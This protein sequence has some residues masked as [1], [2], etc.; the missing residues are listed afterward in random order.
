MSRRALILGVGGF[1]GSHLAR[2]LLHAGWEVT[3]VVRDPRSPLLEPRLGDIF[4]EV[5]LVAGNA[6]DHGLL[7]KLL[8]GADAVFPFAGLSGATASMERPLVDL[9]ANGR[10]QLVLLE[11]LRTHN[12]DAHVVYPGSRLQYGPC[13]RL[14]VDEDHPQRPVSVYGVH[15]MLAEQYHRLY[16]LAHEIPTTVFRI[17]NPYGPYQYRPDAAFGIVGTFLARAA[18]GEE[19]QVYGGGHQLRDY[20]YIGD[21]VRLCEVA[22]TSPGSAG[23]AYNA[24]GP[25][26]VSLRE[27]AE[28]V[29]ATVGSGR[30]VDAP[31]PAEEGAV[32]TGDYV[33]D[34]ELATRELG[35]RAQVKLADGLAATWADLEPVLTA[36]R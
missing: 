12:P 23:Q 24:S 15:K 11:M 3:G 26:P 20:I 22:V 25:E 13:Q 27:M 5:T 2:H 9:N 8:P 1:L 21:L 32:E 16:A 34:T 31:W 10:A 14:P 33:G 35:W 36:A 29:V 28:T 19:L 18:R 30:V 17:S 4:G 7:S 6:G